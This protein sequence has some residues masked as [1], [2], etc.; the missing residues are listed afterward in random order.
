MPKKIEE[1]TQA[2]FARCMDC[3]R[4]TISKLCKAGKLPK[5]E[6]GKLNFQECKKLYQVL[7]RQNQG[8]RPKKNKTEPVKK[9]YQKK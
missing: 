3:H 7:N 8:G 2:E 4:D 6:N 1:V 5:L 9:K